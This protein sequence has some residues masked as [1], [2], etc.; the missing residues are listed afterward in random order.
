MDVVGGSTL[1]RVLAEMQ[2]G[3]TVA[4]YG[5]AGGFELNTT[6]MPFILRNVSLRGVDS[7]SCPQERRVKVWKRLAAAMPP[8]AY[9]E[10]GCAI[11][12]EE[13]PQA[14]KDILAGRIQRRML[15]NLNL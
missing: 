5:L 9:A 7:V 3:G 8:S 1:A 14:A 12:L 11:A 10:L 13:V 4:A 2:Y 15:V 6:V